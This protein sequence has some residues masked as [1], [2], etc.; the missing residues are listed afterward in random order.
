MKKKIALMLSMLMLFALLLGACGTDPASV[1]YNGYTYEELYENLEENLQMVQNVSDFLEYYELSASDVYDHENSDIYDYLVY[2]S[3]TDDQ[4]SAAGSWEEIA[5]EF[6]TYTTY[7]EDSFSVDKAGN[8]LTT[9]LTLVFTA[10]DGS[11]R[12]VTFEVVYEYYSMEISGISINPVYSMGEK[13]SKAGM[14]TLI[15]M[16]VVFCVLI[17]IS[18]IIYAFNIFPYLENKKKEKEK[19]AAGT[20]PREEAVSPVVTREEPQNAT[21]DTELIAVIAAAIAASEGT[22]TSDFVVRSINRR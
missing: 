10:D 12:D 15:S 11:T 18:L 1:D 14:N 8:T 21:D 22:S 13:L 19:A 3:V 7:D 20:T 4:I 17:L 9:D 16:S 6:G 2:C 5:D